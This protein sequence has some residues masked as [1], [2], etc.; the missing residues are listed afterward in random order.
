[1]EKKARITRK[2]DAKRRALIEMAA[3]CVGVSPKTVY[4]TL[5]MDRNNEK[6]LTAYMMLNDGV[7]LLLNEVKKILPDV[8]F[9][10]DKPPKT[11]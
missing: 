8:G 1:M 5:R 9:D 6:A 3:E 11:D 7:N 10:C 2:R 4:A